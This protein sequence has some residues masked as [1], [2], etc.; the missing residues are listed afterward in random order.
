VVGSTMQ[1]LVGQAFKD[2]NALAKNDNEKI[3]IIALAN[4][5]SIQNNACLINSHVSY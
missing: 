4:W 5:N 3:T 2:H 1:N